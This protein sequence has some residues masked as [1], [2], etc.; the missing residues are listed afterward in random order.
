MF[1]SLAVNLMREEMIKAC[2]RALEVPFNSRGHA[3]VL[4]D[5][6][7]EK[8]LAPSNA[9]VRSMSVWPVPTAC[10]EDSTRDFLHSI[11]E[12][13]HWNSRKTQIFRWTTRTLTGVKY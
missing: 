13:L 3:W 9:L 6:K 2:C 7:D 4:F 12:G 8:Q 10:R 11:H 1:G 5:G